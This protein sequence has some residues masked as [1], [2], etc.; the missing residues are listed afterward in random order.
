VRHLHGH[1]HFSIGKAKIRG[2][3][4]EPGFVANGYC[5][6][7]IRL[8]TGTGALSVVGHSKLE[9]RDTLNCHG[10]PIRFRFH[11]TNASGDLAGSSYRGVGHYD[12]EDNSTDST[13]DQTFTLKLRTVS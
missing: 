2:T 11:T 7:A 4:T 1:G 10:A 6:V 8:V 5:S 9:G 3:I 13:V 12:V